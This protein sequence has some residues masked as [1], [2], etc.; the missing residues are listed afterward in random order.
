M[1]RCM[2]IIPLFGSTNGFKI[3][4]VWLDVRMCMIKW[5]MIKCIIAYGFEWCSSAVQLSGWWM[6]QCIKANI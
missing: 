3:L 4:F 6:T 2:I 5:C 1:T